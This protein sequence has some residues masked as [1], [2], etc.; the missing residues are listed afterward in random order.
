MRQNRTQMTWYK[1]NQIFEQFKESLKLNYP[2]LHVSVNNGLVHITGSL[3]LHDCFGEEL[4]MYQI[5]IICD[6][7]YPES[8]PEVHEIGGRIPKIA[9]RH[10]FPASTRTCLLLNDEKHKYYSNDTPITDFLREI[11]EPFFLSQSH[12]DRTGK[13]LFGERGH[14]LKGIL[15]FY[16]EVLGTNDIGIICGFLDCVLND[17]LK[18]HWICFCGSNL[19]FRNCHLDLIKEYRTKISKDTVQFTLRNLNEKLEKE[20]M[21][22]RKAVGL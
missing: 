2:T 20:R 6:D 8:M 7:M 19:T 17:N 11:V 22:L 18:G 21:L 1:R 9:D 3:Y 12:Y 14:G 4:D 13:W 5:K 10:F 16:E 15:E